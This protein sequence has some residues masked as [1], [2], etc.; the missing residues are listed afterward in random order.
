MKS[1][2]NLT[3][4]EHFISTDLQH[5]QCAVDFLNGMKAAA[6]Q[7]K[8]IN[9]EIGDAEIMIDTLMDWADEIL[10]TKETAVRVTVKKGK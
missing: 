6:K 4:A 9:K 1:S 8:E 3:H 2:V 10:K 7:V 5:E